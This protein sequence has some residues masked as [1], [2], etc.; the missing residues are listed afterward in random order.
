MQNAGIKS[1]S[2]KNSPNNFI[3]Q[4]ALPTRIK[5]KSAT[6]IDSI[7]TNSYEHNSNFVS[8]NI[9]TNISGHI[10]QFLTTEN[11]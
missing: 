10:P 3:S 5:E 4:I 6:L 2:K 11:I 7:F 8:G 1:L 9:T